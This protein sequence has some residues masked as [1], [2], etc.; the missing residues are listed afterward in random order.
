MYA[1]RAR[2]LKLVGDFERAMSDLD[3]AVRLDPTD[4]TFVNIRADIQLETGRLDQAIKDYTH[5]LEID[6]TN[7]YARLWRGVTYGLN[8]DLDQAIADFSADYKSNPEQKGSAA[9]VAGFLK[10]YANG[11]LLGFAH[12][13]KNDAKKAVAAFTAFVRNSIDPWILTERG[14]AYLELA[15][16]D[17]AIADFTQAIARTST[18]DNFYFAEYTPN[19]EEAFEGRATALEHKGEEQKAR[20]DRDEKLRAVPKTA[21]EYRGRALIRLARGDYTGAAH[22]A[23]QAAKLDSFNWHWAH[24]IARSMLARS[25]SLVNTSQPAVEHSSDSLIVPLPQTALRSLTQEKTVKINRSSYQVSTVDFQKSTVTLLGSGSLP[26][27]LNIFET[28][29]QR[30]ALWNEERRLQAFDQPYAKSYAI[31]AAI[32]D[33]DR[34]KGGFFKQLTGMVDRAK[35]LR[36][37]LITVGFPEQNI[38]FLPN[39]KATSTNLNNALFDF[40]TGGG[41]IKDADRVFFYFGGH[42]AGDNGAGYL[43][44]FDFD[45]DQ[46]LRT[47]FLMSDVVDRHFKYINADH[48]LVAIDSCSSGLAVPGSRAL[49]GEVEDPRLAEFRK[50]AL[51]RA[52]RESRARNL[53]VAGTGDQ[54][55]LWDTGGIF[56]RAL[57]DGLRGKADRNKDGVVQ[58]DELTSYLRERV[59]V[60]AAFKQVRQEPTEFRATHYGNGKVL[61]VLPRTE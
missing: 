59:I 50:L 39:E 27:G 19:H 58:Y 42:G 13:R 34:V 40:W 7:A 46:Y 54:K 43:I 15:E 24:N 32:D 16:Y 3:E 6:P 33:Y 25:R 57:I 11:W 22:D 2:G 17:Q 12:L 61:F 28:A 4:A 53:I 48:V 55:A 52:D 49:T 30:F 56:T 45:P 21:R 26:T 60:E 41:R 47:T 38:T 18:K 36:N 8:G 51:I 20:A 23:E 5:S 37:I 31:I 10:P 1:Q 35:E 9:D 29:A 14:R 44:T